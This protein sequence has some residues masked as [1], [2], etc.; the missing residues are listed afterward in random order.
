MQRRWA[1]L[2]CTCIAIASSGSSQVLEEGKAGRIS[3]RVVILPRQSP[4]QAEV[5]LYLMK[6]PL[7]AQCVTFVKSVE[8]DSSGN[9]KA[10]NL[11]PG[12]YMIRAS[13][14]GFS[15][16]YAWNVYLSRGTSRIV[17]LGIHIT[18]GEFAPGPPDRIVGKVESLS[19]EMVEDATVTAVNVYNFDEVYQVRSDAQGNYCFSPI[20]EGQYIL[21]ALKPGYHL[22]DPIFVKVPAERQWNLRLV[23]QD[24]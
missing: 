18:G 24:R 17:D 16:A 15:S 21:Y 9:Y 8:T 11:S 19:K 6:G 10:D 22:S 23:P 3:G 4:F 1:I 14:P 2:L 7:H 5:S 20:V 12:G 13:A